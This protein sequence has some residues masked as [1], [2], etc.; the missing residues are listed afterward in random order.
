MREAQAQQVHCGQVSPGMHTTATPPHLL[1]AHFGQLLQE[2][3]NEVVLHAVG[4]L[5]VRVQ[6]LGGQQVKQLL[7]VSAEGAMSPSAACPPLSDCKFA[8]CHWPW[9]PHPLLLVT[10][11]Q[12]RQACQP[13]RSTPS[14][15]EWQTC[16]RQGDATTTSWPVI[17]LLSWDCP[18]SRGDRVQAEAGLPD[19]E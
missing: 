17:P 5:T 13:C 6:D 8:P 4:G 14:S 7:D 11:S 18:G 9:Q 15:T 3:L 1:G 16:A 12:Q 19:L 10:N 2:D